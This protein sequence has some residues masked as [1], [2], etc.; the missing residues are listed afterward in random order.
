M[1]SKSALLLLI[2]LLG[3]AAAVAG[4]GKSEIVITEDG[5]KS[6][7]RWIITPS[8]NYSLFNK[9]RESWQEENVEILYR[10]NERFLIGGEITLM[11][12]PPAG[13]DIMYS[14]LASWYPWN[15]LELHAKLSFCPDADFS[16]NQIYSGGFEYLVMPRLAILM[17]YQQLNFTGGWIEQIKPGL[18]YWFTDDVAL[19]LRYARGWAF[20]NLTYNY[21]SASLRIGALP[22]GGQLTLGFAYGTD[23]DLDFGTLQTSLSN[24]FIYTL[25][26]K[27]PITRDLSVF[28]GVQYVYRLKEDNNEE[29]YQQ[30]TPTIGL[31][32][33]F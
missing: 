33:K 26:Y 14:V 21:Y 18:T 3:A 30:L 9:G 28:A 6:F 16:P 20:G 12:R 31:T 17:D 22:G 10:V 19:T 1:K 15:F 8:F 11:Q 7:K 25:F 23:P 13:D 24:A 4:D 27:Q 29:L 32:W 2:F 5:S